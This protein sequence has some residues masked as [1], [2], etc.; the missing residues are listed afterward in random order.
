LPLTSASAGGFAGSLQAPR[1]LYPRSSRQQSPS[2]RIAT[3]LHV[4][5]CGAPAV[6]CRFDHLPMQSLC[7]CSGA[8]AEQAVGS[9]P[10][11]CRQRTRMLRL[12]EMGNAIVWRPGPGARS[13]AVG[14]AT[15]SQGRRITW[16]TEAPG[17]GAAGDSARNSA[18][19]SSS[20]PSPDAPGSN[21]GAIMRPA[22]RLRYPARSRP[23]ARTS[24]ELAPTRPRARRRAAGRSR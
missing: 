8:A 9:A 2:A 6:A 23:R 14:L 3:A 4:A 15:N 11:E 1:R 17:R 18:P 22:G 24:R 19:S 16:K 5:D 20:K 12:I 7:E 21:D 13:Q 10:S